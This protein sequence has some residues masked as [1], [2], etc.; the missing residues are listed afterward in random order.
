MG[1]HNYSEHGHDNHRSSGYNGFY[2]HQGHSDHNRL[3]VILERLRGN[4]KLKSIII[5][6]GV[7]LLLII[8]L[9][10]VLLL[11][12]IIKLFNYIMQNGLQ[13]AWDSVTAFVDKLWKGSK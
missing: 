9:L 5:A 3:S 10:I 12:L 8:I 4:R 7:F 11:P 1:H 2:G 13:G 6:G